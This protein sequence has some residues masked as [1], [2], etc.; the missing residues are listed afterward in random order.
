MALH[1]SDVIAEV[2]VLINDNDPAA[3]RYTDAELI[4]KVDTG[5]KRVAM[6]RPDLFTTIGAVNTIANTTIQTVPNFGRVV[7]VY[8]VV[9]GG[10]VAPASRDV[11]DQTYPSWRSDAPGPAVNWMRHVR[12]P[13]AFFI[14]PQAPTGQQLLCEYTVAPATTADSD[15]LPTSDAYFP[16]IVD[17]SV[18]CVEWG[19]DEF[20]VSQRAEAFYSRAKDALG[21]T[22]KNKAMLDSPTGGEPPQVALEV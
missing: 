19:D 1:T 18:A 13:S 3:Y 16:A 4:V 11:L 17:M 9:G 14:Y 22:E 2:R 21:V 20:L 6:F 12:N 8:N 10:S 7:D 15:P 5:L